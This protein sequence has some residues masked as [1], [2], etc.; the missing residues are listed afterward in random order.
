MTAYGYDPVGNRT[1]LTVNGGAPITNTYNA[2]N[3]LMAS[4]TDTYSYD[5]N[6]SLISKTVNSV[7]TNFTWDVINRLVEF[8]DGTTEASWS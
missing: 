5:A 6:G 8:D 7:T 4:G 2:A 1:S 3:E